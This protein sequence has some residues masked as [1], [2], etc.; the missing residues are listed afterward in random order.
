LNPSENL[1]LRIAAAFAHS[2]HSDHRV[3]LFILSK[4]LIAGSRDMNTRAFRLICSRA[5]VRASSLA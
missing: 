4:F 1:Q 5:E 3:I 2:F